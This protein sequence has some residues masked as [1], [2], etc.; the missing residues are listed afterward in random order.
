MRIAYL[1]NQYPQPSQSF[2]RREIRALE[3][4]GVSVD[5]FTVR[6][7]SGQLV[8]PNDQAERQKTEV[9]LN[10]RAAGL[11]W[12]TLATMLTRPAAFLAAMRLVL[13]IGHRS[14]RGKLLHLIYLAEACVLLRRLRQRP[15]VA[16]VH[17]HFGTNSTTVAMLCRALGGPGYSFTCHGPEEFD[18]P[19]AIG[20]GEKVARSEFAVSISDFGRSQLYRWCGR[21]HWPKVH[22]VHCGLDAS[23]LTS[24]TTPVPNVPRLVCVG[25]LEE[26]KGQLLLL[27]A[28]AKVV[29]E[30]RRPLE[31]VLV[32]DGSMRSDVERRNDELKLREN[33]RITGYVSNQR[34]REE[35]L[36]GRGLVMASFAEGLPV[37]IME[38][39][40]QRR[41]VIAT[42]VAAIPE[43]VRPGET[44]WLVSPGSVD[45]LATAMREMLD[46]PITQLDEFGRNGA[47]LVAERHNVVHEAEQLAELFRA[48][49]GKTIPVLSAASA[50]VPAS[51]K[52]AE[53]A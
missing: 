7:F 12:A 22:V 51:S 19:E 36:S 26:Q 5:R 41:P 42:Y 46:A 30:F 11:L 25:R 37:V 20:L 21:E 18:K 34:V 10:A 8:D 35:L 3:T 28:A 32:G 27:D 40:A 15:D 2:I 47:K 29:H 24:E 17:A 4:L 48:A 38:A 50:P 1:I 23:F 33:V 49:I 39:L 52:V 44:G 43:L 6:R 14:E 45:A 53:V 16:H 9:I 13:H 31:L